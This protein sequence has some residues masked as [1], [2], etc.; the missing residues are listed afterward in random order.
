MLQ[1]ATASARSDCSKGRTDE[2]GSRELLRGRAPAYEVSSPALVASHPEVR[3]HSRR[4]RAAALE[5]LLR[6]DSSFDRLPPSRSLSAS[7]PGT[8]RTRSPPNAV[9]ARGRPS[10]R[11]VRDPGRP[12]RA[13]SGPES[14]TS[15]YY[16]TRDFFGSSAAPRRATIGER[17]DGDRLRAAALAARAG[18]ASP[19]RV[20]GARGS[21]PGRRRQQYEQVRQARV[22]LDFADE[23]LPAEATAHA[24][25][26]PTGR[27]ARRPGTVEELE[28]A[29][30]PRPSDDP[31]GRG[32]A[33]SP[34]LPARRDGLRR[35]LP[36]DGL[37]PLRSERSASRASASRAHRQRRHEPRRH[38]TR[39]GALGLPAR[40]VA[41][42]RPGSAAPAARDR[43]LGRQPLGRPLRR[44]A[45]SRPGRRPRSRAARSPARNS[46]RSGRG[47]A[48]VLSTTASGLAAPEART[49]L[50]LA[51]AV[52][53]PHLRRS[54][55]AVVPRVARAVLQLAL[56]MLTQVSST[57]SCRSTTCAAAARGVPDRR[58]AGLACPRRRWVAALPAELRRRALRHRGARPPDRQAPRPADELLQ[59][60]A[61]GRHP[62]PA[63]GR[64]RSASSSS[65]AA[66]RPSPRYQ[67]VVAVRLMVPL[68]LDARRRLPGH[69]CRF[70]RD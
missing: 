24:R 42:R 20:P 70:T 57:G 6:V 5:D 9:V 50:E 40:S 60:A 68:Q 37:P 69:A 8:E 41:R 13:R 2:H 45:R 34:S 11:A 32:S 27:A 61:D 15:R 39:R 26:R 33:A 28:A 30:P 44:G 18:S 54:C 1:P 4:C 52:L 49:S 51:P 21:V 38:H 16:R 47:Y 22:P 48:A 53:R 29:D 14:R 62:A 55:L 46:P 17:R 56:P 23:I 19:H 63:A 59:H 31:G 64:R 65:R 67:L 7:P 58:R 3:Q 36:G 35:R 10:R 43:P 25:S 66:S 12:R